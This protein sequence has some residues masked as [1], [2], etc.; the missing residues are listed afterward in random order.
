MH[1]RVHNAR[2]A[3]SCGGPTF[4]L[5]LLLQAMPGSHSEV[6]RKNPLPPPALGQKVAILKFF[7]MIVTLFPS[8]RGAPLRGCSQGGI[9]G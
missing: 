9:G 2:G 5:A 4:S 7:R 3:Q 6:W 1:F 8:G